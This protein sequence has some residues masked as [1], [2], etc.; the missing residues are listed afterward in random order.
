MRPARVL[1]HGHDDA[2]TLASL[3]GEAPPLVTQPGDTLAI[4]H[5]LPRA[6]ERAE[7]FLESR[8]YYLEWIREAWLAE[9]NAERLMRM[10]LDP[11]GSL[12]EMAPEFKRLEPEM[13][14]SFWGSRYAR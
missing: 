1:R 8:G 14:R 11:A 4:V 2:R 9:E 6:A 3:L 10:F 5:E 12:R 7:I 13:E